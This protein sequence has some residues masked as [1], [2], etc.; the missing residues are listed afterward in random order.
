MQVGAISPIKAGEPIKAITPVKAKKQEQ[1]DKEQEQTVQMQPA[2]TAPIYAY[3][4]QPM[5]MMPNQPPTFIPMPVMI[6]QYQ[7][8]YANATNPIN[9]ANK[10]ITPQEAL[11]A[12]A[13]QPKF[14]LNKLND[15]T[16]KKASDK[17][18]PED[19]IEK[20]EKQKEVKTPEKTIEAFKGQQQEETKSAEEKKKPEIIAPDKLKPQLDLDGLVDILNSKD[21]EEQANAMEAIAQISKLAPEKA[22]ELLDVKV[23]D[24]LIGI[25]SQDTTKVPE[26]DKKAV[27][28][29]KEYAMYTT[30]IL[31]KQY[32]DGIKKVAGE[33]VPMEEIVGMAGI[34]NELKNDENAGSREAALASLSYV[35]AP[36]YKEDLKMLFAE[37]SND[38]DP[39]VK[40][41]AEKELA[42]INK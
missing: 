24:A 15:K 14:D 11:R 21:Y 32:T 1:E 33:Q 13:L 41:R 9:L 18:K 27:Q 35:K 34:V 38:I 12:Q 4:M 26:T 42:E 23:L 6:P 28:R 30:A 3:H 39:K 22:D 37:A 20:A 5:Y 19:V 17:I 16:E 2:F 8:V 40:A 25:M 10:N 36:E 31:Q 7:S 29:N